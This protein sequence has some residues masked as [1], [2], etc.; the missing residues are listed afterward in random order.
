MQARLGGVRRSPCL[1][2]L[3]GV[4]RS[5]EEASTP[6]LPSCLPACDG[7]GHV[8]RLRAATGP[9]EAVGGTHIAPTC[10]M[11]SAAL[12]S[13]SSS[14]SPPPGAAAASMAASCSAC[15]LR[16]NRHLQAAGCVEGG[17]GV[18]GQRRGTAGGGYKLLHPPLAADR[19]LGTTGKEGH[20]RSRHSANRWCT[21]AL[22]HLVQAACNLP[23]RSPPSRLPLHIYTLPPCTLAHLQTAF[24]S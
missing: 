12:H 2:C 3:Q 8:R 1:S 13:S 21:S 4:Q 19:H 10:I 9:S 6:R 22:L 20:T 5:S 11:R 16:V 24:S 18:R 15:H 14:G 7:Q 23:A 17:Q